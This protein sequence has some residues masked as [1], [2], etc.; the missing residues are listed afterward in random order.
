[1]SK[2]LKRAH[3][4]SQVLGID[5]VVPLEHRAR[6]MSA[7]PH[8][9]RLRDADSARPGDEAPPEVVERESLELGSVHRAKEPLLHVDPARLRLRVPE[10]VAAGVRCV[11]RGDG[12]LRARGEDDEPA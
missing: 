8:D 4:R 11:E 10:D 5:D 1:V 9:D 7:H 6:A 12:L 2:T 3:C